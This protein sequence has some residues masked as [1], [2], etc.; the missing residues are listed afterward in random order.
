MLAS[1]VQHNIFIGGCS[2]KR[3]LAKDML[4]DCSDAKH[5]SRPTVS[6]TSLV[7]KTRNVGVG[8]E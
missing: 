4:C 7:V 6:N 3:M 2:R 5:L 1:N 8:E